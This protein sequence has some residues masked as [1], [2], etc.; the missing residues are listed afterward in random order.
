MARLKFYQKLGQYDDVTIEKNE[1]KNQKKLI[2]GQK[3]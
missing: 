3:P 2:F 1:A